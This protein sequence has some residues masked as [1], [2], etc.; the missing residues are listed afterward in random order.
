MESESISIE[1]SIESMLLEEHSSLFRRIWVQRSKYSLCV[2]AFPTDVKRSYLMGVTRDIYHG[3]SD[4][5]R[6]EDVRQLFQR[7]LERTQ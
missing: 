3:L 2:V 6:I 7:I 4:P 1:S 5:T